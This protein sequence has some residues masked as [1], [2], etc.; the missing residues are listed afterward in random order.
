[1]PFKPEK[2][3]EGIIYAVGTLHTTFCLVMRTDYRKWSA[4]KRIAEGILWQLDAKNKATA[5]RALTD[6][7]KALKKQLVPHSEDRYK[8][9]SIA[10]LNWYTATQKNLDTLIPPT[11]TDLFQ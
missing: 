10:Q 7:R 1:M 8:S 11:H 4:A 2:K 5:E 3:T 6:L 9:T